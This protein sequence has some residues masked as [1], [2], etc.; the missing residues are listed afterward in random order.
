MVNC[1]DSD[2]GMLLSEASGLFINN[3]ILDHSIPHIKIVNHLWRRVKT[4]KS[5]RVILF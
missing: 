2:W 4:K 1:S 3:I 5:N